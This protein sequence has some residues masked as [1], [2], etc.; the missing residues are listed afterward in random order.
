MSLSFDV[1][2]IGTLARNPFWGE[3][4]PVR[5]EHAT[6]TL[7][8]EGSTRI[9]VDPSLSADILATRLSERAGMKPAQ[10]DVVFL[11]TWQPVHRRSL[12][13]FD[14][15]DWLIW[16]REKTALLEHLEKLAADPRTKGT[17]AERLIQDERELLQRCKPA[18]EKMTPGIHLYPAPGVSPGSAGLLLAAALSTVIVAGDV[19]LSRDYL[20]H[21]QI[22]EESYNPPEARESLEDVLDIADQIIP[23][24]DNLFITP[25]RG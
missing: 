21:G 16:D 4:G 24:H 7:V 18:P 1:I 15:A 23:G 17:A 9:L 20:E 2:T 11:T 3:K 13:L 22:Y 19:I 12:H 10:I 5:T 8:R 14:H 6:T 25:S